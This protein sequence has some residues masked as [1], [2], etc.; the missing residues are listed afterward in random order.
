MRFNTIGLIKSMLLTI[1]VLI[2]LEI[3][4]SSV[5]PMLGLTN[6]RLSFNVLIVL[7]LVLRVS[8]TPIPFC[9]ML[10]QMVHSLFSIEGWALGTIAGIIVLFFMNYLKDLIHFSSGITTMI[11]VQIS[12][13]GW[14]VIMGIMMSLKMGDFSGVFDMLIRFLPQSI[15]LSLISPFMFKLLDIIWSSIKPSSSD[16]F[17]GV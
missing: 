6:L 7:Y 10:I 1:I 16:G 2:V 9:I 14:F 5:I 4:S 13:L 11:T 15:V 12:Q 3:F 8:I 17:G